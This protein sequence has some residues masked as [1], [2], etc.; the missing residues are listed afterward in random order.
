MNV[1]VGERLIEKVLSEK[2]YLPSKS[3]Q[4]I[5]FV[6]NLSVDNLPKLIQ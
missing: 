3:I 6:I 1:V 4:L 5:Y 2:I